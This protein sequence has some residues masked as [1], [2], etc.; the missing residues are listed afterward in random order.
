M[1]QIYQTSHFTMD[2]IQTCDLLLTYVKNSNLN[3]SLKESPFSVFL[4]IKKTFVKD[5]NGSVRF[6]KICQQSDENKFASEQKISEL[7]EAKVANDHL[8]E[9]NK[10]LQR[11]LADIET[12]LRQ[13]K[14]EK[15]IL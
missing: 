14:I 13:V 5:R 7:E 10:S 3:F 1:I 12:D 4:S 9:L 2:P 6:S 8:H 15:D 11:H